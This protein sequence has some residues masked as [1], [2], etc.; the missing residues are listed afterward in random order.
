MK[1]NATHTCWPMPHRNH[2]RPGVA[3]LV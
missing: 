1:G 3:V 2:L